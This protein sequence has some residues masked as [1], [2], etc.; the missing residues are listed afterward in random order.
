[1]R[2]PPSAAARRRAGRSGRHRRQR[3]SGAGA[4]ARSP[5]RWRG[6]RG[7]QGDAARRERS[8]RGAVRHASRP[9]VRWPHRAGA[10]WHPLASGPMPPPEATGRLR[11][12]GGRRRPAVRVQTLCEAVEHQPVG[13]GGDAAIAATQPGSEADDRHVQACAREISGD[14]GRSSPGSDTPSSRRQTSCGTP[15]NRN[16]PTSGATRTADERDSASRRVAARSVATRVARG[17]DGWQPSGTHAG[18][19]P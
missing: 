7:S 16:A 2:T 14:G 8:C 4:R 9:R 18:P 19:R 11:L 12:A 6:R 10:A 5:P 15:A 3:R 17:C 13:L 1:M